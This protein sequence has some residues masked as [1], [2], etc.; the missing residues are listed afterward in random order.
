MTG[1]IAAPLL[2]F[3][4][5]IKPSMALRLSVTMLGGLYLLGVIRVRGRCTGR[6]VGSNLAADATLTARRCT[7]HDIDLGFIE[8]LDRPCF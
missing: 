6:N 8:H 4:W 2:F 3:G 7:M 1:V 5:S